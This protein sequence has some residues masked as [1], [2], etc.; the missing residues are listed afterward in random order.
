MGENE[1]RG[2]SG[3]RER[4]NRYQ[5]GWDEGVQA[6]WHD[7]AWGKT[8]KATPGFAGHTPAGGN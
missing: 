1:D 3:E 8:N 6:D 5:T 4:T 7:S 2:A